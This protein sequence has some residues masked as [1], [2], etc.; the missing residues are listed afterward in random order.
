[1]RKS[2]NLNGVGSFFTKKTKRVT[3]D[4]GVVWSVHFSPSK[5]WD[6]L[7]GYQI[8]RTVTGGTGA[9][10][11]LNLAAVAV[12]VGFTRDLVEAGVKDIVNGLTTILRKGST[13]N[14]T[15]GMLGKI[16]FQSNDIRFKFLPTFQRVLNVNPLPLTKRYFLNNFFTLDL[17]HKN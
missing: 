3:G 6:K 7:P 15:M 11:P 5:T 8:D 14:L 4:A 16:V 10:E 13:A 12:S 1:M 9:A 2:V 17:N